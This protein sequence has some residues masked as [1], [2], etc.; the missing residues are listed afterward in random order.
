MGRINAEARRAL[1]NEPGLV[2]QRHL[3]EASLAV[4]RALGVCADVDEPL[5]TQ[6]VLVVA[7]RAIGRL[8]S[9]SPH[10]DRY[11]K[12]CERLHGGDG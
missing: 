8:I 4:T 7:A 6:Q 1:L 9:E 12:M 11:L 3:E 5:A 10:R 2:V